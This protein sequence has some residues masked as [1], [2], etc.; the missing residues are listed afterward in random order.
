MNN[1]ENNQIE[2]ENL[3]RQIYIH[4]ITCASGKTRNLF[5]PIPEDIKPV[6]F[7]MDCEMD[8]QEY[9]QIL[10]QHVLN[11]RH[12]SIHVIG[13]ID[14]IGHIDH[15]KICVTELPKL[16]VQKLNLFDEEVKDDLARR[17][18]L[19]SIPKNK[20]KRQVNL[21]KRRR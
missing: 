13:H 21:S 19:N 8:E 10:A 4:W 5:N 9:K 14:T 20:H 2:D 12:P 11:K 16:E 15:S 1:Q 6:V 17:I 3:F 18:L 7:H